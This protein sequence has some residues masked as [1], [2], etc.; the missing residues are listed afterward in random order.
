M[1][2]WKGVSKHHHGGVNNYLL[3]LS[4]WGCDLSSPS[5]SIQPQCKLSAVTIQLH[6]MP[7][8]IT[9]VV[10]GECQVIVSIS[11]VVE[12]SQ[13]TLNNL[14]CVVK[15]CWFK[16]QEF[17]ISWSPAT[18]D[19]KAYNGSVWIK[20]KSGNTNAKLSDL[21]LHYIMQYGGQNHILSQALKK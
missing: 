17:M 2:W 18:L 8:S 10:V 14:K 21:D 11:K 16:V 6:F 1:S 12:N 19:F 15:I 13:Q 20:P 4:W 3:T 7:L 9:E 5:A